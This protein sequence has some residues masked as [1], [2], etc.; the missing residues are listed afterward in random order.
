MDNIDIGFAFFDDNDNYVLD[1]KEEI[2]NAYEKGL[3]YY[4]MVDNALVFSS[5]EISKKEASYLLQIIDT[6]EGLDM[7][8][9]QGIITESAE[10]RII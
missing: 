6:D 4:Q 9:E 1:L 10:Y 5:E 3:L 2:D 7:A 8:M